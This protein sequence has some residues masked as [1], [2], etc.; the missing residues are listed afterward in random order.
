MPQPRTAGQA[1]APAA[2]DG[3]PAVYG[4]AAYGSG[5]LIGRLD[6]AGIY[7]GIKC[8]NAAVLR[9]RSACLGASPSVISH[10][11]EDPATRQFLPERSTNLADRHVGGVGQRRVDR[12][13]LCPTLPSVSGWPALPG[14]NHSRRPGCP[15]T[16]AW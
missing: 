1:A 14:K 13:K 5:E 8:Q 3:Q 2:G 16:W 4:D 6:D 7:N 11:R 12:R 9:N 10:L 15:A